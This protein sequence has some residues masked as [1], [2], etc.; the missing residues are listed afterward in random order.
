MRLQ[1]RLRTN[2][3]LAAFARFWYDFLV[4]DDWIIAVTVVVA[5]AVHRAHRKRRT[6][7]RGWCS[8]SRPPRSSASRPSAPGDAPDRA[9]AVGGGRRQRCSAAGHPTL[10]AEQA[11]EHDDGEEADEHD[12]Q[13]GERGGV[14]P[15]VFRRLPHRDGQ[16][17]VAERAQQRGDR[18]LLHHLD[19]GRAD[20]PARMPG[21][22]QRQVHV[23]QHA[24]CDRH[25]AR[26]ASSRLG[27]IRVMRDSTAK[28][29]SALK[30]TMYAN[31]SPRM[32]PVKIR[33]T[34]CPNDVDARS[35]RS[36]GRATRAGRTRPPRRPFPGP[37]SPPW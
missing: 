2:E 23:G 27:L 16:R 10:G 24:G 26:A 5:V 34:C 20:A 11:D 1:C 4:G 33:P 15:G 25:P 30:R 31:T 35:R 12:E 14:E 9:P 8:R 22:Q 13:C 29:A 19:A 6:N 28:N 7:S 37:R 21:P 18:Q 36:G 32:E 3:T 17:V